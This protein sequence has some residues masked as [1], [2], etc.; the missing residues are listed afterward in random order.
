MTN[1]TD[2]H[3]KKNIFLGA[4]RRTVENGR[5]KWH[6]LEPYMG[7]GVLKNVCK[8]KETKFGLKVGQNDQNLRN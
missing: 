1:D 2:I 5:L 3:L 6:D 8:K 7:E 4:F